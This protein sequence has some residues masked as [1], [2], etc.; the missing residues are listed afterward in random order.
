MQV[1]NWAKRL[2]AFTL[3]E[4][5]VVIAI[6]AV[7]AG[8][9][10]PALAQA[11][12]K[13]R[14]TSCLSN[15]KQ[16]GLAMMMYTGDADGFFPQAYYYQ[17]GASSGN[18]YVH[19]SGMI[20]TYMADNGVYKCPT[21]VLGGFAPTCFGGGV[22][23]YGEPVDPPSGQTSLNGAHD[24]QVPRMSYTVNEAI[25]P[26]LK[27]PSLRATMCQVKDG[28]IKSPS[29]EII[30]SEFTDVINRLIDSS[31][32]GGTA[33]KS[34]RPTSGV[35]LAGGGVYGLSDADATA[36]N[37]IALTPGEARLSTASAAASPNSGNHHI[38]YA[39]WDM[40]GKGT[41]GNYIFADGHCESLTLDET[42]NPN[43]F[44]WGKVMYS[45]VNKTR[46]SSP[47][48]GWVN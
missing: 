20:R 24:L 46:V 5:L 36:T 28:E 30:I 47:Y 23:G 1:G 9:L 38:C 43:N 8:M 44:R 10:L 6:I 33:V 40:H 42:L 31:A 16:I 3:I 17:D 21:N 48:G 11:R 18:G 29:Q 25:M 19:W 26:R 34:H 12:E 4:L 32:T 13:A 27:M 15:E 2:V 22:N 41:R 39:G 14:A 7:L 35:E 45:Q 37:V